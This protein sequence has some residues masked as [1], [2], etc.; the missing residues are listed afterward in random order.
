[1]SHPMSR[2]LP[3]SAHKRLLG[4]GFNH[5]GTPE[6]RPFEDEVSPRAAPA[7]GCNHEGSEDDAEV[8]P[9]QGRNHS[10]EKSATGTSF[11]IFLVQTLRSAFQHL[12]SKLFLAPKE[13]VLCS[14]AAVVLL[15]HAFTMALPKASG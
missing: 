4:A 2:Q 15:R 11:F 13:D 8:Q 14:L 5:A 9:G 3:A 12:S 6:S 7:M 10:S 1:M